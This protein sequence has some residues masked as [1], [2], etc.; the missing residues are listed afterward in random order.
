MSIVYLAIG[1]LFFIICKA[2]V[3]FCDTLKDSGQ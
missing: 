1:G 3:E 2:F